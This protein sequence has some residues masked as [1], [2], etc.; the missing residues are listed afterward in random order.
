MMKVI[1]GSKNEFQPAA[2]QACPDLP[3]SGYT[4]AP[5]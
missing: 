3:A 1:I 2:L 4:A 5:N